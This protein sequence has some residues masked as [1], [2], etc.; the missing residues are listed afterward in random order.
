MA[1]LL[2]VA[3]VILGAIGAIATFA[4]WHRLGEPRIQRL[5]AVL[6]IGLFALA[7]GAITLEL[8][9][10]ILFLIPIGIGIADWLWAQTGWNPYVLYGIA[11]LVAA[12]LAW[13]MFRYLVTFNPQRRRIGIA[14]ASA[15]VA[16]LCFGLAYAKRNVYFS[17]IDG[18]V[19]QYYVEAPDGSIEFS[20]RPGFHPRWGK[21]FMPV[22][23][24]IAQ[25]RTLRRVGV[26]DDRKLFR[27]DGTPRYA[28]T[29]RPDGVRILCPK[30]YDVYIDTYHPTWGTKCEPIGPADVEWVTQQLE[31]EPVP[32]GSVSSEFRPAAQAEF[33]S[34]VPG[35][36]GVPN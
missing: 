13:G 6:W 3:L 30:A 4:F 36:P 21:Q 17:P 24:E 1:A 10:T 2:I 8:F 23:P 16:L 18:S 22:T 34:I 19:R 15:L 5:L 9:G 31:P 20:H 35:A 11:A 28:Y 7:F 27:N 33:R 32:M 12:P 26:T 29:V 14:S 25:R